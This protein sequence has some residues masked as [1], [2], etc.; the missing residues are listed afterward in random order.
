[1]IKESGKN[2][3]NITKKHTFFLAGSLTYLLTVAVAVAARESNLFPCVPDRALILTN[4]CMAEWL[5]RD[6]FNNF[7]N[8]LAEPGLEPGILM[9]CRLVV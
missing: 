8:F 7:N 4:L 9:Y 6:N 2:V 5:K 1:M 3:Q